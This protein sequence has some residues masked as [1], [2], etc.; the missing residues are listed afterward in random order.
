M[1][2]AT[3]QQ[4]VESYDRLKNLKLVGEEIGMPWQ[5]VYVE[6]RKAGVAVT[7]DKTRYGSDK[8]RLAAKAEAEFKRLIPYAEDQ[9]RLA[10]QPKCDFLVLGYAVDVKCGRRLRGSWMFS[11]KK[12]EFCADFIVCFAMMDGG[13]YQTLLLPGELVRR[14][15]TIRVTTGGKWMAYTIAPDQLSRFFQ[16]MPRKETA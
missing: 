11:V 3:R 12:Q 13:S 16:Q 1:N 7:G 2:M 4:C 8:D 10:F 9:N 15:Q 5:T 6:L 14:Y